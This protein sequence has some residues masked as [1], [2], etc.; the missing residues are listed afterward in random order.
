MYSITIKNKN[1]KEELM[2]IGPFK[3]KEKAE[4]YIKLHKNT[5]ENYIEFKIEK[6]PKWMK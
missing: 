4:K 2:Y 1:T 3:T 6:K 5:V